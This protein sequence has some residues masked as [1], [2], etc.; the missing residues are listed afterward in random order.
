MLSTTCSICNARRKFKT[1]LFDQNL[2]P[3]CLNPYQCLS[4]H[5]NS[6]KNTRQRGTMENLLTYEEASLI[7]K[8]RAIETYEDTAAIFHSKKID[9]NIHRLMTGTLGFRAANEAQAKYICYIMGKLNTGKTSAAIQYL[10][11]KAMEDDA[12]FVAQQINA[13]NRQ[14]REPKETITPQ[15]TSTDLEVFDV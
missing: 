11:A 15:T 6:L 4:D 14:Y 9:V 5:P 3:Y 8:E 7:E 10:V 1:L 13:K 2:N 12:G